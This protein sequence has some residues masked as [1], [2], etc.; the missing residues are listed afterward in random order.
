[1]TRIYRELTYNRGLHAYNTLLDTEHFTKIR[2]FERDD[3]PGGNWHYSDETPDPVP[4]VDHLEEDWWKGDYT[5]N[6]PT[7]FPFTTTYTDV[8]AELREKLESHRKSHRA[9]KPVWKSLNANA[10]SAEMKVGDLT[11][12][13]N[14]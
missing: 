8:N 14:N 11:V 2:M 6:M 5:A 4:I 3:A 9:P 13:T 12:Y 1:V 10:P 7:T